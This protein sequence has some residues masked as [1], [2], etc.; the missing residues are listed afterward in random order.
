MGKI[1][2]CTGATSQDFSYLAEILLEKGYKVYGLVRRSASSNLWRINHILDKIELVEGDLTDQS[3]LDNA[4]RMIKPD[5]VY[6]LAAQSFVKYSFQA[7]ISTCDITGMGVLRLLE[8]IRNNHKS[9]RVFQASSSEMFG[10]IQETPQNE[11]T[12][13]YPRSPYGA[14]K[15]FGH[16]ISVNYREAYGIFVSCG[17]MFN[18]ESPRRGM[19][20]V[21]RKITEGIARVK[22]GLL[23]R[24]RLGNLNASRD[25]SHARD[26]MGGA[27][28]MLQHDKPEDF[29]LATG[30]THTVKQWLEKTCE[31]A[32]LDY[33]DCF[34]QDTTFERQ[35]EV[36]YLKGD[37]S[38]AKKLLGWEPK[39]KFDG[40]VKEM[41]EADYNKL[42]CDSKVAEGTTTTGAVKVNS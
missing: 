36:D 7:P 11:L 38:K 21:T 35:S 30:E 4:I 3:S 25:W 41:Y 24:V 10:K 8:A 9:A 42:S 20:F 1:A 16:Q 39:W 31:V 2:F 12:R 5:E 29:V 17:I 6:N 19:E 28:L 34:A 22:L 32:E 37:Y 40:L 26:V 18:H 13:F 33:W 14:A 15:A 23:D 27:Y